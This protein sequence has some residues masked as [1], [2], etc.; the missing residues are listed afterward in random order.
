[1]PCRTSSPP[2]RWKQTLSAMTVTAGDSKKS[3]K[4]VCFRY[5]GV[6]WTKSRVHFS[7]YFLYG[8][9]TVGNT[10]SNTTTLIIFSPL[11]KKEAER[12]KVEVVEVEEEVVHEDNEWGEHTTIPPNSIRS[13]D[14]HATFNVCCIKY[15]L[16]LPVLCRHWTGIRG[17][18][19]RATGCNRHGAWPPRRHHCGIH[20]SSWGQYWLI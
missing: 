1:M 18:W 15:P 5:Q 6:G 3:T 10:N 9:I 12:P 7:T 14:Q 8:A 11:Q 20:H 2:W 19:C 4:Y 16:T 13:V 17:D